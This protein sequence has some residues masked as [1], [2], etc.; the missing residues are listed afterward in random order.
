MLYRGLFKPF[1]C[2]CVIHFMTK[3]VISIIMVH[4]RVF[5]GA[6]PASDLGR[7]LGSYAWR[8]TERASA[9]SPLSCAPLHDP[10]LV[11]PTATLDEASRRIS[12]LYQ[13]I[14]FKD[15]DEDG[16][17]ID[18][19]RP[20]EADGE[21]QDDGERATTFLTWP[22]TPADT[23]PSKKSLNATS[24][25][26]FLLTSQSQPQATYQTQETVYSD[27]NTSAVTRF[28]NFQFSLHTITSLSSL[29]STAN[30]QDQVR[31]R[32]SHKV[33]VLVV[34]L[35]VEGPDT[36]KVKTG[37]SA[38]Q[39]VSIL[40]FILGDEEGCVCRLTAW[41]DTAEVWGGYGMDPDSPPALAR[42]DVVYFES[43]LATFSH[44][45]RYKPGPVATT[46]KPSPP[47]VT[48]TASPSMRPPSRAQIC[49]RTLS[50]A[51]TDAR[52]RPDLRLGCSDAAVRHVGVLVKW[53]EEV[54][55]VG[56]PYGK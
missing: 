19:S 56:R 8:T 23:Q 52:L 38:G 51:R 47:N 20:V 44:D 31:Q 26:S 29:R 7:D 5:I 10:T 2:H 50:T 11:Y 41:R 4:Y 13:N 9:S 48:F 24:L 36:V 14:I 16:E 28:P 53:F 54:A 17:R 42:G 40:K 3:H 12:L 33:N 45:S 15:S 1:R 37:P 35:E 22:P 39:E 32:S 34:V 18:D 30:A 46:S 21:T 55:G 43:I 6:P 25:P 49:Y 27:E